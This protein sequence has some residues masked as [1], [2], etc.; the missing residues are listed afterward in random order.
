M[1]E[2]RRLGGEIENEVYTRLTIESRQWQQEGQQ[3]QL[4]MA[5]G[6][7]I[8]FCFLLLATFACCNQGR[9]ENQDPNGTKLFYKRFV[10]ISPPER[11]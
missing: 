2:I 7:T 5:L 4:T 3:T 8:L 1:D 9:R 6:A 10:H 11:S